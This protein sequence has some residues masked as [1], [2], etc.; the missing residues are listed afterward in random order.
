MSI[1]I[2]E[3]YINLVS[4]KLLRFKR[5]DR[6]LYNF[7]CPICGDSE[8]SKIKARGW[9]FEK[10][11]KLLYYCHNCG[12]S[13][14]ASNL[15][16][17][18]D[19]VL[20]LEYQKEK[21][22]ETNV[23]APTK[24]QIKNIT[25]FSPPKFINSKSPLSSL[26]KISSLDVSHPFKK[27]VMSRK[28]PSEHH[29]KLFYCESFKKWVN[30]FLPNKFED[31]SKDS[32]RLIIPFLDKNKN[33]FGCQGRSLNAND[34]RYITIIVDD[35][36]PKLFGLD[37]CDMTKDFYVFEGPIDSLFFDNSIAMCGS[38]FS[39]LTEKN[40]NKATIVFD[41][42][43]RSKQIVQKMSKYMDMGYKICFWPGHIKGKDVNEMILNGH[44]AEE[45][46]IIVDKNSFSGLEA[47]LKLETWRKC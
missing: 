35:S 23:N 27:Y 7:R 21:F 46:K 36:K 1:W 12:A 13:M 34:I 4:S 38:D 24:P 3:K 6:N 25:S 47:K 41:N 28:I 33:F 14:L 16:K 15:L 26:K 44:D 19:P 9:V 18:L 5:K 17:T 43:P 10:S 20:F 30:T 8:K 42:E 31:D 45:I 11:G 32:A 40:V 22:I 2:E 39:P 37:T 29:Y